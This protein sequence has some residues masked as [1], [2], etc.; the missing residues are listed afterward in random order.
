LWLLHGKP[1]WDIR[2]YFIMQ[3]IENANTII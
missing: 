3:Q 1:P 2:F